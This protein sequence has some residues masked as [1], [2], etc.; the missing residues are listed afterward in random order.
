MGQG[1]RAEFLDGLPKGGARRDDFF[2]ACAAA[3]SAAR[4]AAGEAVVLP[5]VPEFDEFGL[6][7][8]ICG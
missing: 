6:P 5:S 8:R 2:D 4:I 1:Y 3:W 7:M